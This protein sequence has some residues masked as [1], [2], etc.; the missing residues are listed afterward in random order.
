MGLVVK[1]NEALDL[2]PSTKMVMINDNN[3]DND[4]A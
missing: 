2:I 1:L 3:N 4:K